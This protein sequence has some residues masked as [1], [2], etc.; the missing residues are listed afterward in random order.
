MRRHVVLLLNNAFTADSRSWKL[1]TSVSAAVHR[2][3]VVARAG[4]GLP[5]RETRDGYAVIRVEQPR[6]LPWLPAPPLPG[7]ETRQGGVARRLRDTAGRA[8]QALRY[9]LLARQWA[10][11]IAREV[12]SADIWQSEG[13]VTL[14]VALR[15]RRHLGGRVVYDSRDLHVRSARFARLPGPWRRLL[16]LTERRW[17]RAADAVVTV[18]TPYAEVLRR[19][20]GVEPVIVWNGPMRWQ[21]PETPP[22]LLHER[23]GLPPGRPVVL[24]LGALQ[25][26][27]GIDELIDAMADVPDAVL[28]IVGDGP[29]RASLEARARATGQADRI[30]FLGPAAPDEILPLTASADVSVMPVHGSTLNHRLNTPTKLFDAMGA[31]T[32]V[33]ASDLPGMAAIVRETGCGVLCDPTSPADI[34]R[35]IRDVLD[36]P[37][38][39]QAAFR[40][41]G[42]RAASMTYG[43]DHQVKVL[44]ALYARLE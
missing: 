21:A 2:V 44:L 17:A 35:A 36:A 43:W 1:A 42:R 14:P 41:A 5:P 39:R 20:L 15:L 4:E 6:P 25:P 26:H 22:R 9:L 7:R 33:V 18:S 10:D 8:A 40:E 34:A 31:G 30:R 13:L 11:R 3:T 16:G 38:E 12:P 27:R 23:L 37:P 24:Q 28:A 32:P 19:T 29:E